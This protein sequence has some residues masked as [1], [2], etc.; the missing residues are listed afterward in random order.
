MKPPF[1]LFNEQNLC[2]DF[3]FMDQEYNDWLCFLNQVDLNTYLLATVL[4]TTV[5]VQPT[6]KP[7]SVGPYK[8]KFEE[9]NEQK[10]I[11]PQKQEIQEC[12]YATT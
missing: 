5:V 4:L 8:P 1:V 6:K 3:I 10:E 2:N 7:R 9:N 12:E 11:M